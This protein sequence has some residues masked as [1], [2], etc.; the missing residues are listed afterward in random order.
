MALG[1]LS[2]KTINKQHTLLQHWVRLC[3]QRGGQ[4]RV[5]VHIIHRIREPVDD[6]QLLVLVDVD[7]HFVL[8]NASH[9]LK[10]NDNLGKFL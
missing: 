1:P 8:K 10:L 5:G 9:Q 2:P 6:D 4:H 3:V 7:R